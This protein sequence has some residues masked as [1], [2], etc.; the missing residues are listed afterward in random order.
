MAQAVHG[1]VLDDLGVRIA[2]GEL[3]AGQVLTLA[4][5]ED[6]YAVSRT[7]V[8]EAVRVLES[9]GLLVSRRRVGITVQPT[10]EWNALDTTLI[11]WRLRG[12]SRSQQLVALTE[13][14]SAIE[15]VAAKLAASRASQRERTRLLELAAQLQA[16]GASE[17]G[18]SPEYLQA[19]IEFHDLILDASGN[20]LLAAVKEPISQVLAGRANLG[21]TPA[22]PLHDALHNHVLTAQAIAD[23]DPLAAERHSK[24]YLDTILGEVLIIHDAAIGEAPELESETPNTP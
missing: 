24:G 12:N 15:P 9:M 16:L 18:D 3:E 6:H 5:L 14:R 20:A 21:L 1:S 17:R 10:R 8:R 19:D 4:A 13:L 23:G 2:G 11:R 22:R 7:V